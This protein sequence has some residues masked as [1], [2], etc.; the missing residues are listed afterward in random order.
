MF[1]RG[2]MGTGDKQMPL[3]TNVSSFLIVVYYLVNTFMAPY[4]R[5]LK[6]SPVISNYVSY[7]A[8][9]VEKMKFHTKKEKRV[10]PYV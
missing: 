4:G 8:I 5:S 3:L 9:K 7:E 2:E 6:S 10:T 1:G